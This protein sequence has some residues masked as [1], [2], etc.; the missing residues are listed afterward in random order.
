MRHTRQAVE[1]QFFLEVLL[2]EKLHLQDALTIRLLGWSRHEND[3][4]ATTAGHA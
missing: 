2:D 3:Y 1:R 4:T